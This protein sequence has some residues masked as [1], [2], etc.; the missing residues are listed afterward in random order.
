MTK[1]AQKLIDKISNAFAGVRLE[2]GISLNMTEYHDAGGLFPEYAKK[3]E[4]DER[5]DWSIIP[6]ETL[7]KFTVTFSFTDLKGFRFYIPAYM[8]YTIRNYKSSDSIISDFTIYAIDPS[9]YLFE[10]T[11]FHNWFTQDQVTAMTEFLEFAIQS[12]DWLDET[13]AIRNLKQ[14]KEAQPPLTPNNH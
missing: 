14:I 13:V 12:E 1:E 10:S 9:H 7:E 2:D 11:S 3:A 6:E 8:I 4:S 5:N